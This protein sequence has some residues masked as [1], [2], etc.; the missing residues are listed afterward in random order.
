MGTLFLSAVIIAQDIGLLHGHSVYSLDGSKF[1]ANASNAKSRKKSALEKE[2]CSLKEELNSYLSELKL[3]GD[4]AG[5]EDKRS[6]ADMDSMLSQLDAL[7]DGEIKDPKIKNKMSLESSK[8]IYKQRSSDVEA[9]FGQI[10]HNRKFSAFLVRG[11]PKVKAQFQL[12]CIAHNLGKIMKYLGQ[13]PDMAA[14]IYGELARLILRILRKCSS[15]KFLLKNALYAKI[16]SFWRN[17]GRVHSQPQKYHA[18]FVKYK[19]LLWDGRVE[20][21]LADLLDEAKSAKN[22]TPLFKLHNYFKDRKERIRYKEFREKGY[23]IGSGAIES[24]NSYSIQNR[25]KRSRMK[26]KVENANGLAH[27]RN[28]YYSDQWDEIWDEIWDETWSKAA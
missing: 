14:E 4:A 21:L 3:S 2:L 27:L 1:K 24:A 20:E 17:I 5:K 19:E 15:G 7:S 9:V 22:S 26:W 18:W 10:K 23:F 6:K 16:S 28:I 8:D 11:L 12:V 25:L 13:N